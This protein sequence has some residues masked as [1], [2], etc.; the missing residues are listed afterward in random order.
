[1]YCVKCGVELAD[2]EQR[3]PLCN[4][5]VY[6]PELARPTADAPFP[7]YKP[8]TPHM[9]RSGLLFIVT[10]LFV[11]L[12]AQLVICDLSITAAKGW[13]GFAIGGVVLAYVLCVLPLWF[14]RPNPVILVP[15]DYAAVLAY[16]FYINWQTG[17]HWF[18]PFALPVIAISCAIVAAVLALFRY[19]RRGRLFIIGGAI[20]THGTFMALVEH[21]INQTFGISNTLHWSYFPVIGCFLLGM[22]L[23]VVAICKPFRETL[24]KKFFV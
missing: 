15:C 22:G 9:S 16:L 8:E 18:L 13:A 5:L 14:R 23:I 3:C 1:M 20:I 12:I 4:T 2:S 11:T 10:V 19:V 6:H 21:L 7:P 17:G 24:E